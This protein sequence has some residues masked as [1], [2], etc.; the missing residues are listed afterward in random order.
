[1]ALMNTWAFFRSGVISTALTETRGASNLISLLTIT[2]NSLLRSS[3]TLK[4][5]RLM[6]G[7]IRTDAGKRLEV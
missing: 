1:M 4:R 6:D 3:Q 5:R 2:L 7:G